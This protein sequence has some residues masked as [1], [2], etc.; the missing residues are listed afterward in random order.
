MLAALGLSG[1]PRDQWAEVL[2][3]HISLPD[4]HKITSTSKGNI[5]HILD[6]LRCH[7]GDPH[8]IM[9]TLFRC[10]IALGPIPDPIIYKQAALSLAKSHSQVLASSAALLNCADTP[11]ASKSVYSN[12]FCK[13][14]VDLLPPGVQNED[15]L[16]RDSSK[17]TLQSNI[18]RYTAFTHKVKTWM[19]LLPYELS[20]QNEAQMT[21][22]SS[23]SYGLTQ[24]PTLGVMNV[25]G[26]AEAN[27]SSDTRSSQAEL[28]LMVTEITPV[29][30]QTLM[31]S[32]QGQEPPGSA[33]LTL[34]WIS[35]TA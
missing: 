31:T 12:E 17:S 16:L 1:M 20:P 15:P 30:K 8:T 18:Y 26:S 7:Y 23:S 25:M 33:P 32:L 27:Q 19:T 21:M 10:H 35:F 3:R 14:L 34:Q 11:G 4:L 29:A 2:L 22:F 13:M 9:A 28:V 6:D 24:D 5:N